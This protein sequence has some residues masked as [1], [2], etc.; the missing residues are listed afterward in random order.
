MLA[1]LH[2]RLPLA[3]EGYGYAGCFNLI[4]GVHVQSTTWAMCAQM[5]SMI[6]FIIGHI[7]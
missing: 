1:L 4:L 7:K 6:T 3:R 2:Y 5:H